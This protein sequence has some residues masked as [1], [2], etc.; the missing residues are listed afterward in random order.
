MHR[1]G[2][3]SSR[4]KQ[5][6]CYQ[7]YWHRQKADWTVLLGWWVLEERHIALHEF[8]ASAND[9]VG[10]YAALQYLACIQALHILRLTPPSTPHSAQQAFVVIVGVS[11]DKI[12]PQHPCRFR[13]R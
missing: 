3:Y 5:D 8:C 9:F 10:T 11:Q 6:T 7:L 4:W 2:R 1:Y 12:L 13:Q